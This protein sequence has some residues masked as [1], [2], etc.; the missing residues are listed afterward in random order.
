MDAFLLLDMPSQGSTHALPRLLMPAAVQE[1]LQHGSR[2]V[3]CRRLIFLKML[4]GVGHRAQVAGA[5]KSDKCCQKQAGCRGLL[6]LMQ[7]AL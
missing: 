4:Q 7:A 6:L 3:S 1:A 5:L 2:V